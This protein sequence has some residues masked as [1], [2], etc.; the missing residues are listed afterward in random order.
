MRHYN[1]SSA[2][3]DLPFFRAGGEVLR[4]WNPSLP[5]HAPDEGDN[6]VPCWWFTSPAETFLQC[7]PGL[8]VLFALVYA[9]LR[10]GTPWTIAVP[11]KARTDSPTAE[12]AVRTPRLTLSG[13]SGLIERA[14]AAA[15]A[16]LQV[17]CFATL[18]ATLLFKIPT[19]KAAFLLQPCHW[20]LTILAFLCTRPD[21][22]ASPLFAL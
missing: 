1:L 10:W 9:L 15:D 17:A 2:W 3:A 20:L 18:A 4:S 8:V 5:D 14:L 7:G 6:Q 16:A 19:G 13:G 11:A 21:P 22:A 12:K